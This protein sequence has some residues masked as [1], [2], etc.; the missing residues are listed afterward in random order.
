MHRQRTDL[1]PT[2]NICA[3]KKL[4]KQTQYLVS[5]SIDGENARLEVLVT[6]RL[7]IETSRL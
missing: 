5:S 3:N 7:E 4:I 1:I 6:K 2:A